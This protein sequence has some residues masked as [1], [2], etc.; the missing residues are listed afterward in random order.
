[1]AATVKNRLTTGGGAII[2]YSGTLGTGTDTTVCE[3]SI[4]DGVLVSPNMVAPGDLRLAA[5]ATGSAIVVTDA[6]G[7]NAS[8]TY[9]MVVFGKY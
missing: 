8:M 6:T 9:T 1:M 4:I 7:A 2:V 3:L 5:T